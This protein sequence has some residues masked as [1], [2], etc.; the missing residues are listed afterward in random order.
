MRVVSVI[1]FNK[2]SG[3]N[4]QL[5]DYAQSL[6][7]L[8]DNY[9]DISLFKNGLPAFRSFSRLL[10]YLLS[11]VFNS[12]LRIIY[13]DPI[14][15]LL[16]FLPGARLTRFVQSIDHELYIGHPKLPTVVQKTLSRVIRICDK[17]GLNDIVVCSEMC[18]KYMSLVG[19]S[20]TFVKPTLRITVK[21]QKGKFLDYQNKICSIM[22]NP[23]LKGIGL[24]VRIADAFP[25]KVFVLISQKKPM[26]KL[27]ENVEH[28]IPSDRDDLF[29]V[30][31]SCAAHIS[32]SEKESLGLPI[33][34]A[35]ALGLPSI[36]RVNQATKSLDKNK[37][38]AFDGLDLN[39][40]NR[41][42]QLI[43]DDTKLRRILAHQEMI[44]DTKFRMIISEERVSIG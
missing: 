2:D 28:F 24:L 14:L 41:I 25:D 42:F 36:F 35:M 1:V 31:A 3:G 27:P 17:S 32:C 29:C 19:R 12:R 6:V 15:C 43:S 23:D 26:C 44:L 11:S 21:S 38:L 40:I 7:E 8:N 5:R 13:S 37:L 33:Y 22:S 10:F 9:A 34:E 30:A 39:G 18:A 4:I 16:E 20:V